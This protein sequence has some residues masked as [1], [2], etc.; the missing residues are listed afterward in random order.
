M[1]SSDRGET[2]NPPGFLEQAQRFLNPD[3]PRARGI[4]KKAEVG[5]A[6]KKGEMKVVPKTRLDE[7]R[8]SREVVGVT[9]YECSTA[10]MCGEKL[11]G[12]GQYRRSSY[13]NDR[14][15]YG[16]NSDGRLYAYV[17]DGVDGAGSWGGEMAEML[18]RAVW[19][20]GLNVESLVRAANQLAK[21]LARENATLEV[22]STFSGLTIDGMGQLEV[23]HTGDSKIYWYDAE[24]NKIFRLTHDYDAKHKR[25]REIMAEDSRIT[26]KRALEMADEQGFHGNE[27]TRTVMATDEG[28]RIDGKPQTISYKILGKGAYL[29]ISDGVEKY[30][31][32]EELRRVI[33]AAY[34]KD[35][36]LAG[37]VVRKAYEAAKKSGKKRLDAITAVGVII[38]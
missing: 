16:V 6:G 26:R 12:D 8:H 29:A 22:G 7:E 23:L 4:E 5:R 3:A 17:A 1:S 15:H 24:K 18:L 9:A 19:Q 34:G 31:S 30:L 38:S 10:T 28:G 36:D 11:G 33:E 21:K 13:N 2:Y 20:Y 27:L 14:A 32:E 35:P 25:A 37:A